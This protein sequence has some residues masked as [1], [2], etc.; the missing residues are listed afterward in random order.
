MILRRGARARD[1]GGFRSRRGG[2][3]S[4]HMLAAFTMALHCRSSCW[5]HSATDEGM[6]EAYLSYRKQLC[7]PCRPPEGREGRSLHGHKTLLGPPC[8]ALM[9]L[10]WDTRRLITAHRPCTMRTL[11][12]EIHGPGQRC[13]CSQ[14]VMSKDCRS[15]GAIG[16]WMRSSAM[17]RSTHTGRCTASWT[18]RAKSAT[19]SPAMAPCTQ[20]RAWQPGWWMVWASSQGTE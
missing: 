20:L 17:Y 10:L 3:L 4:W 13:L 7:E 18:T 1:K 19:S 8:R 12:A 9:H 5:M 6:K 2:V 11:P 15:Q 16:W 14:Q